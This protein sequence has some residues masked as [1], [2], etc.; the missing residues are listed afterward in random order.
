M[1]IRACMLNRLNTVCINLWVAI[2]CTF[3]NNYEKNLMLVLYLN[4]GIS[5]CKFPNDDKHE[6]D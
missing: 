6:H 3:N 1:L 4:I 2:N 5:S